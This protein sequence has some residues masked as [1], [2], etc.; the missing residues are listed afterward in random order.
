MINY[1]TNVKNVKKRLLEPINGLIKKFSNTH[2]FCNKDI[3][4][5]ILLLRKGVY[6]YEYMASW[7]RF[8][9]TSLSDKKYFYSELY[10]EDI[11]NEDY[12]HAQKV[13]EEL[14]QIVLNHSSEIEFKDFIKIYKKMQN[15]ILF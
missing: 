10:F 14:Q 1:I 13:L 15:H 3:N 5:F 12:T 8:N 4:K 11:T 7:E 6:P 9:E 2:K